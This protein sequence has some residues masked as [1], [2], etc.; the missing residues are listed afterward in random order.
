M[1][2]ETHLS[3]LA[4][5]KK[6]WPAYV[7][8]RNPSSKVCQMPSKHSIVMVDLLPIPINN[9][10]IPQKRLGEQQQP[11]PE[12]VIKVLRRMHQPLPFNHNP[13]SESGYYNVLHSDRNFRHC[14]P[15][16]AAWLADCPEYSNLP[17]LQRQ[18][19]F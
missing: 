8:M 5:D 19:S 1:S 10:N 9:R 12:V 3:N 6:E 17:Y 18:D 14:K 7:R 16:L 13:S 15:I 4:A 11:N 2:D